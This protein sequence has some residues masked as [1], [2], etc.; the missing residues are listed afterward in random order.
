MNNVLLG[1]SILISFNVYCFNLSEPSIECTVVKVHS[2]K[3][4]FG[5]DQFPKLYQSINNNPLE[6]K[7]FIAAK[8]FSKIDPVTLIK[9]ESYERISIVS[10]SEN[11]LLELNGKPI[12]RN[13]T[14]KI[15]EI[16]VADVTCH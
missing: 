9:T 16:K 6:S 7:L 4:S 15:N 14:M 2:T 10:G 5:F 13:G 3:R 11:L 1:F 8:E 12:S